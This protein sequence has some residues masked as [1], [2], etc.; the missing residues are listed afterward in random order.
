MLL[1]TDRCQDEGRIKRDLGLVRRCRV[2][3]PH[4]P[5]RRGA[6][7]ALIVSDL[8]LD[9]FVQVSL[10]RSALSQ[11]RQS[12]QPFLC[13]LHEV[14]HRALQ[15][16]NA[17]GATAVLPIDASREQLVSTALRLLQEA[18]A[19]GAGMACDD[20]RELAAR[21]GLV[22]VEMMDAVRDGHPLDKRL[23]LEGAE[24]VLE[25]IQSAGVRQWLDLVL[26]HDDNTYQHCLLVA[27]F[28]AAVSVSLGFHSKDRG[29]VTGAAL[30]HDIGK[31]LIPQAIL[32]K[33][34]RLS[35]EEMAVVRTHTQIGYD[36]LKGQDTLDDELRSA[37]RNHHEFLDGT[38][39]PSGLRGDQI[40]D[41][42]RLLTICDIGSAL[43]E[44]RP[45]KSPLSVPDAIAEM[46][47][48][49]GKLDHD[50]LDEFQK[51]VFVG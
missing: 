27:G 34:S 9:N 51:A 4:A 32:N 20:T 45:Y 49:N 46:R 19:S 13:L 15:Q 41:L 10:L 24:F 39:Y 18:G 44:R 28:A 33:P 8:R 14:T 11:Y 3:T 2:V 31:A 40:P 42:I 50:I 25:A 22:L 48:M 36:M 5:F 23:L 6:D 21:A 47:R 17:L 12:G 26:Q 43:I 16:A 30:L 29:R 1:L 38:G 35:S 37:V 7:H